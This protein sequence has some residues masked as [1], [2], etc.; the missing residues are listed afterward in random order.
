VRERAAPAP[1]R[2]ELQGEDEAERLHELRGDSDAFDW[3]GRVGEPGQARGDVQAVRADE[4]GQQEDDGMRGAG[5]AVLP[6][7][8][9]ELP[10]VGE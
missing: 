7:L 3:L 8:V 6:S 2:D 4:R 10:R 9:E 5:T 1:G